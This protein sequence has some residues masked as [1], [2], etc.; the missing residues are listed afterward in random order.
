MAKR[1]S[2]PTTVRR[3][4]IE[5]DGAKCYQCG[6]SGIPVL[7]YGKPTVV[8]V[9]PSISISPWEL[10]NGKVLFTFEF[11]HIKPACLG[12]TNDLDNLRLACP[13]CNRQN[14]YLTYMKEHDLL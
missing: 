1:T 4:V 13:R 3:E 10:Y 14:H 12:G 9:S 5:K 7:R 2:I 11:D 6:V 8:V